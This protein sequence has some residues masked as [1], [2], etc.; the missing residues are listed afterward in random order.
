MQLDLQKRTYSDSAIVFFAFMLGVT[1]HVILHFT[2]F[3]FSRAIRLYADELRYYDIA[4]SL[5]NGKGLSIRDLPSSFQKIGYSLI[6]MPFFAIK[7]VVIRLKMINLAN[8][9]LINLSVIPAWLICKETGLNR[10]SSYCVLFFTAIWPDM[11]YS[12]TYMSESLYW[13]LFLTMT[14]LWFLNERKQSYILAFIEGIICYL[15]YLTKEIALA[16]VLS[17]IAFE[18]VYPFLE[19]K[20]FIRKRFMILA[21]FLLSFMSCNIIM[22]LTMFYGLGNSYSQTG[23]QAIMSLYKFLYMIYAFFL[24]HVS[25]FRSRSYSPVRVSC[26]QFQVHE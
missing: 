17:N 5:F 10:C 6:M 4:R 20:H 15:C 3:N 16:F 25:N 2:I 9:F 1:L 19:R 7:D 23:I 18:L 26:R 14:Y 24:S 22:K 21:V 12:M 13:P 8:I 11:M